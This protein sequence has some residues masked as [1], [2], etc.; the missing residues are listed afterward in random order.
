MEGLEDNPSITWPYAEQGLALRPYLYDF[1]R[2]KTPVHICSHAAGIVL[3]APTACLAAYLLTYIDLCDSHD[4]DRSTMRLWKVDL[5][6]MCIHAYHCKC[7]LRVD[8]F[9]LVFFFSFFLFVT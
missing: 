8:R 6:A 5:S 3:I 7:F 4:L 9:F 1:T 2:T